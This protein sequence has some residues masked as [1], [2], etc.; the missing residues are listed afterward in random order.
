MA[1][2]PKGRD[3]SMIGVMSAPVPSAW[4]DKANNNGSV[5]IN[6]MMPVEVLKPQKACD[7]HRRA[8][9]KGPWAIPQSAV[10]TSKATTLPGKHV[11][12]PGEALAVKEVADGHVT[13]PQTMIRSLGWTSKATMSPGKLVARPGEALAVKEVANAHDNLRHG[14]APL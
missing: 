6:D 8:P 5:G 1:R 2:Q 7:G 11:A 3:G 10:R 12:R 14:M 4:A 13:G 9:A